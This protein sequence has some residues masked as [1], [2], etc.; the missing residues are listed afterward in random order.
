MPRPALAADTVRFVGEL[1]AAVVAETRAQA[2]DAAEAVL[3]DYDILDAVV[4][5]EDALRGD[6]LLFPEVGTNV[7]AHLPSRPEPLDFSGCEVV[8]RHE[9][10]NP[11]HRAQ[12][13]GGPR[14]RQSVGGGRAPDAL[15]SVPGCTPGARPS[16]RVVRLGR[17]PGAGHHADVGGGFGAKAFSYAEDMLLPWI[18]KRV[19]RP[20]RYTESR[21]ES[22]SGLG[23]GRGQHQVI[24]NGG[25]RDGR[26]TH[27]E[28]TVVQESGRT[29]V[30][31]PSC[32]S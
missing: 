9:I 10:R 28:L 21:S 6:V 11:A 30:S 14:G 31:V 7:C 18:A 25:T 16:V 12:S 2:V 3:V 5:V 26:I 15:A 29:R 13:A 23:H 17:L 1:V 19:G 24:Q 20:V 4:D 8:V 22:M 32:R 27:Y